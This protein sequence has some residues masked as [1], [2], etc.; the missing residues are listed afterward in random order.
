MVAVVDIVNRYD[1]TFKAHC[2]KYP[3]RIK[4]V[5]YI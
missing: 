1:D 3:N 4:L 2:M 5:L